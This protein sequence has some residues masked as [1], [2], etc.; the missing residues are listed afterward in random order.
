MNKKIYALQ[1][2][3]CWDD[4]A[5]DEGCGGYKCGVMSRS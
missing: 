5:D 3:I 4:D 1:R 2:I